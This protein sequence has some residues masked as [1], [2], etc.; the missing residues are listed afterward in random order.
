VIYNRL[1]RT[2]LNV[3]ALCLGSMTWGT[4][5]TTAEGHAQIDMALDHGINFIDTAEMYPTT[6]LS[7][8]TQGD[9]ERVIG[10]WVAAS[11][12]RP[13][14]IIATKVTGQG[15]MNVRDGAAISPATIMAAL[16]A[17]LHSLKTDYIDLYQLHWP[18]RG[19]YMFR[20]NWQYDPTKQNRTA[21]L[22]EMNEILT[23]LEDYRQQGKI[24][25]V[26]LSNE[27]AWG[28]AQ[29][30]RIAEDRDLPRMVSIQNE[31]S[32]LCRLFDTDLAEL[33]HNEDIGLLS[34]SPLACGL[35]TGKYSADGVPPKGS[36]KDIN[37]SLGGRITPRLWPA[38][39]AYQDIANDHGL[40]LGQMALAWCLKRP[41]MTSVIFG[42]TSLPQLENSLKAATLDLSDEIMA[43]IDE[44]HK[45]HPMPF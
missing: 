17:S 9:T 29:W 12:R 36:R 26:G 31:Y 13:D 27:S 18:N 35:L 2:D 40:D 8:D 42:A 7:K 21:I 38:I 16:E 3:S 30:L 20:Q 24:R 33:S 4:Q 1:G 22:D 15:H 41:F 32:L 10:E 11:G 23:C 34:F 5:N 39:E 25:H 37:D 28:T 43:Q 6:P 44:A 14:V 19:S 45:A